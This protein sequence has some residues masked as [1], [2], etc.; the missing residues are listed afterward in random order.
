V[1]S[2][3]LFEDGAI[4]WTDKGWAKII[5]RDKRGLVVHKLRFWTIWWMKFRRLLPTPR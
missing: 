1:S 2:H 4:V 5:G 3:K